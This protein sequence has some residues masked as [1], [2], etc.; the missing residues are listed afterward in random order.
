MVSFWISENV[1]EEMGCQ[2][3]LGGDITAITFACFLSKASID[4]SC[5][6]LL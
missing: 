4:G 3:E 1:V 5:L 6:L 2:P